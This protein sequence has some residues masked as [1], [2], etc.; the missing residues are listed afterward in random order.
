M[1][2]N[3]VETLIGAVVL[4]V[5]GLFLYVAYSTTEVG[6]V[7]G[8]QLVAKFDRIDG[9]SVGSD[10]RISGIKVGSVTRQLLDQDTFEAILGIAIESDIELPDDSSAKISS[11]GILGGSFVAVDPGGS[12]D[13]LVAGDEILFTQGTVDL[14]GLIGQVIH[15]SVSDD[16]D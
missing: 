6:T 2:G 7:R 1:S 3:L 8:Y 4:G 15:G 12:P 14:M 10:V 13:M 9:I 5:A 16:E 11:E